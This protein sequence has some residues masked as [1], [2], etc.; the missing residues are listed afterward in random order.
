MM[1]YGYAE[2]VFPDGWQPT[3]KVLGFS[4]WLVTDWKDLISPNGL[5]PTGKIWN[6]PDGWQ[7]TG[8]LSVTVTKKNHGSPSLMVGINR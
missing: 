7:P 3:G 4:L 8:K 6:F 2:L 1:V 5:K